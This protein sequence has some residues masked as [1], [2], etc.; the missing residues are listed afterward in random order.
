M[1]LSR[2]VITLSVYLLCTTAKAQLG[3]GAFAVGLN[4]AGD[5]ASQLIQQFQN[6]GL[7]LEVNAA[8]QVMAVIATAKV[9]YENELKSTAQTMSA[10]QQ[11]FISGLDGTL[12]NIENHI[13]KDFT[14]NLQQ[15]ANTIPFSKT[16][17]Q[18]TS[19]GGNIVAPGASAV[20]LTLNG[21]F[22]DLANHGYNA[23]A[24]IGDKTFPNDTKTTN[25]LTFMIPKDLLKTAIENQAQYNQVAI[26]IPYREG[27][28]LFFKQKK[29][30]DF[31][32]NFI[33]LPTVAGSYQLVLTTVV[34]TTIS[35]PMGCAKNWDSSDDDQDL[36][37]GCNVTPG[38]YIR[39]TEVY[40]T[41]D[42]HQGDKIDFGN[43][44]TAS[45]AGWH[46]KT[47]HHRIGTSGKYNITIHYTEYQDTKVQR[48]IAQPLQQL[49]WGASPTLTIDPQANW[50]LVYHQFDGKTFQFSGSSDA[51]DFFKVSS[52]GNV[53]QITTAP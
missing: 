34:D 39:P 30:A 8:S 25:S 21:N 46:L 15:I 52:A 20:V 19:Y 16:L 42:W 24:K 33:I 45:F 23:T 41:V 35:H 17:P 51:N 6:T 32:L 29:T 48:T 50:L 11:Q 31:L 3:L 28:F 26:S 37:Q 38:W 27:G 9:A 44:S 5:R 43:A 36:V 18:L 14:S 13:L 1:K 7:V 4:A 10:Q 53:I 2:L 12:D 40:Y 47:E 49:A 22:Y